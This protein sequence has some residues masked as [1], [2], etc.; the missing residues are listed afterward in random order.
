MSFTGEGG[1]E[2]AAKGAEASKGMN[3]GL[4]AEEK[5]IQCWKMKAKTKS[6][7]NNTSKMTA[8]FDVNIS[9]D[10][11]LNVRVGCD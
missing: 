11:N 2:E 8:D 4:I 10:L 7:N 6:F 5:E 9:S 1:K 3:E